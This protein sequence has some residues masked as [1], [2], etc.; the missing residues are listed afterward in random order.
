MRTPFLL[1]ILVL[2]GC[3][4]AP[5]DRYNDSQDGFTDEE[6]SRS[7]SLLDRIGEVHSPWQPKVHEFRD[8]HTGMVV[9]S[10]QYPS[11]WKVISKPIYTVDQKI[12]DFLVQIE[13]PHHLKTFNTPAKF[14]VY[15]QNPQLAQLMAQNGAGSMIRSLVPNKQLF[16]EEVNQRMQG[17]GYTFVGQYPIPQEEA[18]I[19]RKMEEKGFGQ[20]Q[21]EYTATEWTNGKGQKALARII[22]IA[23]PLPLANNE[24]MMLWFYTTDYVFVDAPHFENAL[25]ELTKAV[26]NTRENPQWNTYVT[27]LNQQRAMENERKMKLAAQQHQQQLNARWAAFNAQQEKVRAISAAQDANYASFMNRNFGAGSDVSR[28]QFLNTINEE[29]TVYNP[30]TGSNYQVNAGSTEYWM[31]S[32]GNYI[33]NNDLFYTPN[34]DINLNNREWVKVQPAY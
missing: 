6:A 27:Q 13:G 20:G 7:T 15:Y 12:P 32:D 1:L 8:A 33:Q 21:L 28:Q 22:K 3:R 16:S 11:D 26:I 34:G 5:Q 24:S 29:E 4:E 10:T 30:M 23:I 18:F 31:D 25:Q 9:N 19:R 2:F 14:F 17:S